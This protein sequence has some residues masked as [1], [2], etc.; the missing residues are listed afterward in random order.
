MSQGN[1]RLSGVTTVALPSAHQQA[2]TLPGGLRL[3]GCPARLAGSPAGS[4][5]G[6]ARQS[7]V[8][9]VEGD[10]RLGK[11]LA[12]QKQIYGEKLRAGDSCQRLGASARRGLQRECTATRPIPHQAA[13]WLLAWLPEDVPHGA[14]FGSAVPAGGVGAF[15]GQVAPSSAAPR[16]AVTA[17]VSRKSQK[18][19]GKA[20]G[21]LPCRRA[22][23]GGNAHVEGSPVDEADYDSWIDN[24][25]ANR[26]DQEDDGMEREWQQEGEEK[27]EGEGMGEIGGTKRAT[28]HV[29]LGTDP[30]IDARRQVAPCLSDDRQGKAYEG[31]VH[32]PAAV[33]RTQLTA[34]GADNRESNRKRESNRN[35]YSNG[36]SNGDFDSEGEGAG[37]GDLN[38]DGDSDNDIISITIVSKDRREWERESERGGGGGAVGWMRPVWWVLG[39]LVLLLTGVAPRLWLRS[40]SLFVGSST[41]GVLALLGLD[42]VFN[43]GAAAFFLMASSLCSSV[44]AGRSRIGGAAA[45]GSGLELV[46]AG[47]RALQ[48][49]EPE[50]RVLRALKARARAEE[51]AGGASARVGGGR[52]KQGSSASLALDDN[53]QRRRI[54]N[55]IPDGPIG[56]IRTF[57]GE[58]KADKRPFQGGGREAYLRL[59]SV[60]GSSGSDSSA[61]VPDSYRVW[62][63][64]V[65]TL[66]LLLPLA[67]VAY[68]TWRGL[69]EPR[70]LLPLLA[71]LG[72]YMFALAVQ[73]VSEALVTRWQSPVWPLVPLVFHA[74]R[75]VQ[76]SRA[77]ELAASM[78]APLWFSEGVKALIAWVVLVVGMQLTWVA[79]QLASP[80]MHTLV[81]VV[82]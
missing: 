81:E 44:A 50:P 15:A 60:D 24:E 76:L 56:P 31:K 7:L 47:G 46:V 40:S 72:P 78:N 36:S 6:P 58:A 57:R 33:A 38:N 45:R 42:G 32:L 65:N 11:G 62:S 73:G 12:L 3:T 70:A 34:V 13:S 35:R 69:A 5:G 4:A 48:R 71:T 26:A 80:K 37:E 59:I 18:R 9:N 79:S 49:W 64:A 75:V 30:Y 54:H 55:R 82:D 21:L 77:L 17:D 74:Y 66:S 67:G 63:S 10:S 1:S 61:R 51:A 8:S 41:A 16:A 53:D 14:T 25:A 23:G 29:P 2:S 19:L 28:R 52:N 68:A 22:Q 39:P 27:G 20:R 43:V